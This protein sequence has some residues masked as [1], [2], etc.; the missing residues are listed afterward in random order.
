MFANDWLLSFRKQKFSQWG[1]E[2]IIEK[3]FDLIDETRKNKW[4]V[5]FGAHDGYSNSNTCYF[6]K[7][8]G[9]SSVM[10]EADQKRFKQLQ[11][12]YFGNE[13]VICLNQF[14]ELL[15]EKCLD[16][17]LSNTPIPNDFDLL[18][19]DVDGED[20]HIWKSLKNFFPKVV[21]IEFNPTIPLDM[22]IFQSEGCGNDFGA[23]LLAVYNL[24]KEKGYEMVSVTDVNAIFVRKEYYDKF[25]IANNAPK[26]LYKSFEMKYITKIYQKYNGTLILVGNDRLF[27]HKLKIKQSSIQVLPR[28]LRIF[29]GQ[30]VLWLNLLKK[31]YYYFNPNTPKF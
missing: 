29:P 3:I 21:I 19:V 9:F 16:N 27:W 12:A 8:K 31:I 23:S 2:G 25:K 13:K 7:E 24:G 15:G 14:V 6:I 18:S 20:Y 28:F 17:I 11:K 22:D 26:E 1:E 5:E 4:C 30:D 10:I